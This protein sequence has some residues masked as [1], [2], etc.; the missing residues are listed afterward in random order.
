MVSPSHNHTTIES[1][2]EVQNHGARQLS[3]DQPDE[4]FREYH[5]YSIETTELKI[6]MRAQLLVKK[7]LEDRIKGVGIDEDTTD[8]LEKEIL[9]ALEETIVGKLN[10]SE[11]L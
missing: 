9:E 6:R 7:R 4:S 5:F 1:N 8:E 10:F 3:L 2:I 11:A